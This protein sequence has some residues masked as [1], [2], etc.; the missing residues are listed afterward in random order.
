MMERVDYTFETGDGRTLTD[1]I[2][3]EL[4][5]HLSDAQSDIDFVSDL[6]VEACEIMFNDSTTIYRMSQDDIKL[7]ILERLSK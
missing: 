5:E 6:M 3:Y 1:D 2:S 4:F 7:A